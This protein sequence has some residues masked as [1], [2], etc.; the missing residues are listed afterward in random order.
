[1]T[2]NW[3]RVELH[4]FSDASEKAYG[5]CIYIKAYSK[6]DTINVALLAAKSRVSPLK[7]LTL[8]LLELNAVVLA[9]QLV[10]KFK[11]ILE[12]NINQVFY[13]CDSTIILSWLRTHP[14][15][16]QTYVANRVT[17]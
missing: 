11:N 15:R 1:M 5:T 7:N 13:W 12:I 16:W 4:A 17:D 2:P 10:D 9:A 14:G 6:D 8:P 3:T